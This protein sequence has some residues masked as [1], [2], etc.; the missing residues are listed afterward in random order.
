MAFVTLRD[1]ARKAGVSTAAVSQILHG[2]GRFSAETR[3]LVHKTVQEM[4]YVPDQRARSMRSSDT[5]TVGLLVPDLRNQY[6]ADLVSSMEDELYRNGVSTLI[7]T[8]SENVE[9]QDAFIENLLGQRIDGAIVVPQ[10]VE[11]PGVRSLIRRDLPLV[12]VDRRIQGV[13]SVP[14]VVSNPYTGIREAMK[15]LIAH[16]HRRIG[17]VAHPSLGS[18]SVNERET[19]FRAIAGDLLGAAA[20]TP[21]AVEGTGAAGVVVACDADYESRREALSRLL[22]A[23]VTAI[24]C[25]YSPDAITIIGLMHDR[26][27][28]LGADVSLV[29]F[30]DIA[31]FRL[32]TPNVAVISQQPELMGRRGVALLLESIRTGACGEGRTTSVPTVYMPRRSVSAVR[33]AA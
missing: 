7:G 24:M 18:Y 22:D 2:K 5:K 16:G 25:G 33:A 28:E 14:F 21:S 3:E 15:D 13:E 29:S 9:R 19:A 11:S 20:T 17:Y 27:V 10:G 1:V 32:M 26:G 8:S 31:A 30:D 6:F 4:G 23:H 12:F